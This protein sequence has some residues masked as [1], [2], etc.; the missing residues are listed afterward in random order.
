MTRYLYQVS[1]TKR[2]LKD[3]EVKG[4]VAHKAPDYDAIRAQV[5]EP[6]QSQAAPSPGEERGR[7]VLDCRGSRA[8]VDMK[9]IERPA[10]TVT[11]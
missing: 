3:I 1:V 6:I 7:S 2:F 11:R 5:V 9:T 4:W 10:I 8:A